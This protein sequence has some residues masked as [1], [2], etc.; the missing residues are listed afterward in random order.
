MNANI[1]RRELLKAVVVA[2]TGT[3]LGRLLGC[4]PG[5]EATPQSQVLATLAP[6]P[7]TSPTS[8]PT[9]TDTPAPVTA[10]GT[11]TATPRATDTATAADT[12]TVTPAE[13]A[14]ATDTETA[15]PTETATATD[16][17]TAAPTETAPVIDTPVPSLG[18]RVIHMHSSGA[19]SW[20]G[21]ADYWNYVNQAAVDAMV[22]RGVMA[23][24]GASTLAAA[25]RSLLPNYSPGKAIA[26]KVN[27]NNS[28]ACNDADGQIDALIQPVNAIVRGLKQIGVRETDVWVYDAIRSIPNRF[29]KGNQYPNVRFFDKACRERARF[30]SKDANAHV[31]FHPPSGVPMPPTIKV[32]NVIIDAAYLINMPIMKPHG[33]TGATL[34]FKNHFGTIDIPF[35][36]HPFAGPDGDNY[37]GPHHSVLVDIYRNP[38]IANKTILTVADGLFACKSFSG[39]PSA[40]GTFG[41]QV[42]N[43]LFFST[44]PVAIDCV[45]CDL[46][47]R[48]VSIPD[49]TNQYLQA[50][51]SAGLGTFERGDP[52]GGGYNRIDYRRLDQ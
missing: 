33:L 48:E 49:T 4:S 51:N 22:D 34:S 25:W 27:L 8:T 42:P 24:T 14:A 21:Q 31:S 52:W 39:T 7:T 43:S 45:M 2:A 6:S 5:Q 32:T 35:L 47:D 19:T 18:A 30:S 23:L 9:A 12:E 11:D 15:M 20:N 36:L 10:T 3:S 17:E 29:I 28:T 46:L 50:A 26:V 1:P 44:D 37:F 16:T 38:H 40:W 41:N 13:T